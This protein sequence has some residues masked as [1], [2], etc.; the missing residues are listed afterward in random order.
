MVH[1]PKAVK[2]KVIIGYLLL[3]SF[4]VVSVWFVYTEIIKIATPVNPA[5]DNQKIIRISNAIADLYASE[6]LGRTSILTGAPED[7]DNYNKLLDSIERDLEQIKQDAEKAQVPKFDSI[8]LLLERKRRSTADIISF[9]QSSGNSNTFTRAITGIYNV[10]DSI[11]RRSKPVKIKKKYQWT[12]LVNSLLTPRQMDS[13]SK[14]RVSNDSLAMAFDKVLTRLLIKENRLKY[15]LYQKEQKLLAENLIISDQLRALLSSLE[16]E[17]LHNSYL[18]I[19]KSQSGISDTVNTMAWV[20]AIAFIILVLFAWVILSDLTSNQNYR[21]R[22]ETLN[23]E[24]EQLLRSKTMLMATVTHDLQTPLGSIIGFSDLMDS[25]GVTGRQK[26]YLNN[27]KDSAD[28][29][30][31]LANDLLDFSKLENNRI[32][33]EEVSFNVKALLDSTCKTLEPAATG[34]NI[35]LNWI[36]DEALDSNF[37]SDPYRLKQVITNLVSNAIKF[38]TYGSVEITAVLKNNTIVIS[39]LDTGIGIAGE[40]QEDVFKEFTQAHS[41]IEKKFGGTGLGLTISKRIVELLG[42]FITLESAVGQGSIFTVTVPAVAG[43]KEAEPTAKTLFPTEDAVLAGKRILVVDDDITQL[44]FLKEVFTGYN[45]IVKTEANSSV[46]E[47]L[48]AKES[49]DLVVTDI[50]M[51]VIDGFDL[52]EMIRQYPDPKVWQLPVVALSGRKDLSTE[53][54]TACGFTAHHGK[55][56]NVEALL[57]IVSNIFNGSATNTQYRAKLPV[58]F[59]TGFNLDSLT[60]F[61]QSDPSSLKLIIDTFVESADENCRA[62]QQALAKKDEQKLAEIAHK[63]IPMLRQIHVHNV[64]ALLEP[65]EERAY[66]SNDWPAIEAKVKEVCELMRELCLKLTSEVR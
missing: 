28:Y 31:K 17:F 37:I 38:T 42:G 22:L 30:L 1:K 4:A 55:P 18:K 7:H 43:S 39:V 3:F 36:V 40:K 2:F 19:S 27:I 8:R 50:Q 35:E 58:D 25:S 14:L 62:L 20:G 61:T 60:Q 6:A 51:P 54:F 34:K 65:F 9:R 46:V 32:A 29:I 44:A 13:L 66:D 24:N 16:N 10:K 41:G 45:M 64:A 57:N 21:K 52:I 26:Q 33:I 5:A 63:M 23:V 12:N 47:T 15:E 56:V 11:V 59:S 48:L 53:N 49:F